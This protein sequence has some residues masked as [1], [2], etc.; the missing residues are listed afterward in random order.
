MFIVQDV[1]V[2]LVGRDQRLGLQRERAVRN[3]ALDLNHSG[4]RKRF[5][6]L[7]KCDAFLRW[8]MVVSSND[9]F[10]VWSRRDF[11]LDVE[12]FRE[13]G[14]TLWKASHVARRSDGNLPLSFLSAPIAMYEAG[15]FNA[16]QDIL[17]SMIDDTLRRLVASLPDIR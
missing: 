14:Q 15:R 8:R 7:K 17:S 9:Y 10:L 16:D 5:A 2:V 4:D 12:M 3:L 1:A 11:G 13:T 6:E